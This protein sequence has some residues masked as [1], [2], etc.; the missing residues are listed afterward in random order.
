[1]ARR[2]W[3]Y[4]VHVTGAVHDV[5]G[6]MPTA[7]VWSTDVW[8]LSSTFHDVSEGASPYFRLIA[9]DACTLGYLGRTRGKP[10]MRLALVTMTTRV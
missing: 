10:P 9:V 1:M 5:F 8:S 4:D 3:K 7:D 2:R 6:A